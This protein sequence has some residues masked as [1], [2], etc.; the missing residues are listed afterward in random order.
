MLD[1]IG[2]LLRKRYQEIS[3]L[4]VLL[5]PL[6]HILSTGV[7]AGTVTCASLVNDEKTSDYNTPQGSAG[8]D[9]DDCEL[10][11]RAFNECLCRRRLVTGLRSGILYS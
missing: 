11:D 8:R 7:L 3:L 2:E 1:S 4:L 5:E 10:A 6:R 9:A